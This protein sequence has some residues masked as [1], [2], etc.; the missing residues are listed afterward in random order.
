MAKNYIVASALYDGVA[1]PVATIGYS[2][3]LGRL[4][5]SPPIGAI[6][7]WTARD[8]FTAKNY[9][10]RVIA[11]GIT[12]DTFYRLMI[13]DVGA[14]NVVIV[15]T[16]QTGAFQDTTHTDTINSGDTVYNRRTVGAVGTTITTT[17]TAFTIQ[18]ATDNVPVIGSSGTGIVLSP[19]TNYYYSLLGF[20]YEIT[21]EAAGLY[22]LRMAAVSSNMALYVFDNTISA[23]STL[24]SRING[25]NGN[26]TVTINGG[27]TGLFEDTTH[28]GSISSGQTIGIQLTVGA[29]GTGMEIGDAH[30]MK[31]A[32]V[33]QIQGS[34]ETRATGFANP[35]N[36][37][38]YYGMGD[39][40]GYSVNRSVESNIQC[41]ALTQ[42][43]AK[44]LYVWVGQYSLNAGGSFTLRVAGAN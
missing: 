1:S 4:L 31:L 25:G 29:G 13:N 21:A 32:A 28:A 6:N 9:Y 20:A 27:T 33:G 35:A 11:N 24:I 17:V 40:M 18:H 43:I 15:G 23:A 34:G 39:N 41:A 36:I 2:Q 38:M 3:P 30:C 7:A 5:D 19:S 26:Q 22:L 8:T 12:G 37:I 10:V 16:A 42:F 14:N 44:N